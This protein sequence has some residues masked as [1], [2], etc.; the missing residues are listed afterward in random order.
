MNRIR[1]IVAI[2][3][4]AVMG[5]ALVAQ[6]KQK[7]AITAAAEE[8]TWKEFDPRRPG[9]KL[10]AVSGDHTK[11]SWKGFV[12]YP[13]GAK[14]TL[15]THS[16]DLEIVVIS[17]SFKFGDGSDTE[18]AYGPGSYLFVPA[19][20]PHTNSTTEETTLFEAQPAKFDTKPA[21]APAA[22]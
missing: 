8:L 12:K 13:P 9:A 2:V 10:A 11:G 22:K 4:A 18:K 5:T 6:A 3:I 14:A 16:A 21:A 1:F 7:Q 15:H 20:M 19:G 17:G